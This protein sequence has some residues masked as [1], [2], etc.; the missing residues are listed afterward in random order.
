[1]FSTE[2][3]KSRF[4][5][6]KFIQGLESR[7]MRKGKQGELLVRVTRHLVE[8]LNNELDPLAFLY[9][10]NLARDFYA[11]MVRLILSNGLYCPQAYFML[12]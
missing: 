11:E 7:V 10:E 4:S 6:T 3:W 8:F 12:L 1:M 2:P 9:Q 5:D